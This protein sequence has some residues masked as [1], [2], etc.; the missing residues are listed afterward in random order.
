MTPGL[1]AL[2]WLLILIWALVEGEAEH[3]IAKP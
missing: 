1:I 2:A 3:L